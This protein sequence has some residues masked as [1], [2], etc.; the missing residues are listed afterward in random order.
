MQANSI[1]ESA[2]EGLDENTDTVK[3]PERTQAE[4]WLQMTLID[5]VLDKPNRD[6]DTFFSMTDILP[7]FLSI[8]YIR[9]TREALLRRRRGLPSSFS[10][11][12]VAN[13][14]PSPRMSSRRRVSRSLA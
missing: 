6:G 4:G 5:F 12:A 7:A 11:T 14:S 10:T 8:L 1:M 2:R 13:H 9:S 3:D